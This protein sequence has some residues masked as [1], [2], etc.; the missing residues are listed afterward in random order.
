MAVSKKKPK[1]KKEPSV[2]KDE[3]LLE[4]VVKRGDLNEVV[5]VLKNE[6]V[7]E[8]LQVML[9]TSATSCNFAWCLLIRP[10]AVISDFN[11]AHVSQYKSYINFLRSITSICK[12]AGSSKWSAFSS[13]CTLLTVG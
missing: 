1:I 12:V 6:G 13:I 11:N 5:A 8:Q 2:Q 10:S 3:E 4:P 7:E 9:H